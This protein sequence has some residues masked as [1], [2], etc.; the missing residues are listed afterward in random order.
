MRRGDFF[1]SQDGQSRLWSWL[2]PS[3]E[4]RR[5]LWRDE[6]WEGEGEVRLRT[7][8]LMSMGF[9]GD[10]TRRLGKPICRKAKKQETT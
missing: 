2:G 10:V 7:L 5:E 1:E 4:E 6:D 9:A 8:G 3:L